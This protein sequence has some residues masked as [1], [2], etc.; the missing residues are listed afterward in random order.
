MLETKETTP[1]KQVRWTVFTDEQSARFGNL[2]HE[3]RLDYSNLTSYDQS[4][5]FQINIDWL[6]FLAMYFPTW[7]PGDD[8]DE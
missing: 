7:K 4:T 1:D 8:K 2:K 5:P 6:S 3:E